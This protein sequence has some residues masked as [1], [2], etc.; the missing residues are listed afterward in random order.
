MKGALKHM[1]HLKKHRPVRAKALLLIAS[2]AVLLTATVGSTAAW[3][4]SKPAAVENDFVPGKV[5]CQVLEDFGTES[6]TSVKRN[7]RVKNNGNTDAYI[8][9]MLVFTWKD[10]AGN[11]I[12]NKPKEGNDYWINMDLTDWVM[13]KND[14]G[15]YFYYKKPVAPGAETGVLINSLRQIAGVTG[16]ENGKY[17][18]SVDILSDAVQA[19]PPEAVEESWGVAVENGEIKVQGGV[20]H[21]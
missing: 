17:K 11:I 15:A 8:R 13:E 12:S 6:G 14:A 7:V 3:L 19:N 1:K 5:A 9:V 18:L 21:E 4:V 10:D 16:P 2:L 20:S